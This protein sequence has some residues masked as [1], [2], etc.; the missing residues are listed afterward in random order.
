[1]IAFAAWLL[2]GAL[3]EFGEAAPSELLEAVGP[4]AGIAYAIGFAA[5]YL[6]DARRS[7]VRQAQDS[8]APSEPPPQFET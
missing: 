3:H 8:A 7:P 2:A 6:L 4:F 5:L 1:M